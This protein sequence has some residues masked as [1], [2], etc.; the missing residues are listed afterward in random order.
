MNPTESFFTFL[1][2]ARIAPHAAGHLPV[3]LWSAD[4]ERILF[5]NAVGAAIFGSNNVPAVLQKH[6][7][8]SHPAATQIARL[9]PTLKHDAAPRLEKLRG[10]GAGFGRTLLCMCSRVSLGTQY[11]VLVVAAE[12]AGPNLAFNERIHRLIDGYEGPLAAFATDGALIH[13]T[14]QAS[15]LLASGTSLSELRN[16]GDAAIET[17]G[18]GTGA[19]V[20]ARFVGAKQTPL[21][22][23]EAVLE[24]TADLAPIAQAMSQIEARLE[25]ARA[26]AAPEAASAEPATVEPTTF[27]PATFEPAQEPS[28]APVQEEKKQEEKQEVETQEE[29]E[30]V[31]PQLQNP[32]PAAPQPIDL[33]RRHP[34]RFVWQMDTEGRFSLASGEFVDVIGPAVAAAMG[35][36]WSEIARELALDPDG[37]ILRAIATRNTWSGITVDWPVENSNER[38][39]VELSGLPIFDRDRLFRGYRGFGVCRDVARIENLMTR[40]Y[41]REPD[42][43]AVPEARPENIVPFRNGSDSENGN[44]ATLTP[45]ER[46]AFRELSSRL[47]ARLQGADALATGRAPSNDDDQVAAGIPVADLGVAA[48]AVATSKPE[49]DP[50]DPERPL[51]DRL[52]VGIL[53]YRHSHFIYANASFLNWTGH[54]TLADFSQ[55]GGLDTL[56]IET[57]A[58]GREG[59][60]GQ[61]LRIADPAGTQTPV[62]A[63]LFTI[64]YDGSTAMA[65]VLVPAADNAEMAAAIK[66]AETELTELKAILDIAAD[67]VLILDRDGTIVQ[68]NNR[69]SAI[70][71]ADAGALAGTSLFDLFAPD[72][73]RI[74]RDC[75][76]WLARPGAPKTLSEGRDVIGR[77]RAGELIS[78][79][80]TMGRI[81]EHEPKFCALVRDITAW[82]KS[83]EELLNAKRQAEKASTAKSEF[84]AKIS[85]EIRTPLNAIIGFSEVMMSE[86]FG[87]VGN[88]RY[89]DY[90]RDIHTSGEHLVSLLNDLLDLSKIEAGKLELTFTSV[91]LNEL[92][93]QTVALMQPQA[94]RERIILRQALA[95][96]LPPIHA[97]ARSVRQIAL[98]LLSNAIKFTGAGGQVIV[99]TTL[100]DR[101]DVIL[102]VKDSGAGMSDKDI[103]TA[104]EPFRQL[105]TSARYGSGGSG[106]GLPLTK[107]LTEANRATFLIRSAVNSGT[108]IEIV[109]P[110]VPG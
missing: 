40:R 95:A 45:V 68:A 36:P 76:D 42:E 9:G 18:E 38:L 107:A 22:E 12:P 70:F 20:L 65:L 46:T 110:K 57:H 26:E 83:Q 64:P 14:E 33:A 44:G 28:D 97:D 74:A 30:E 49:T 21:P 13:A 106:L 51:L 56:F 82:K 90:L 35:R 78:L 24:E 101:G 17:I 48:A 53:I 100:S 89:K 88:D 34:L 3:W 71:G 7:E 79:H 103:E 66:T 5:A 52:P 81:G 16:S 59:N 43:A 1:H 63:R 19:F 29:E 86:R 91:E 8:A 61:S 99:S 80:M 109:F 62:D 15:P 54:K 94:A 23:P 6:F 25:E 47:T 75:F 32:A 84:L 85:H 102:R 50:L 87:P 10:F 73:A 31:R 77:R 92:I 104:L 60:G 72:S 96:N 39:P 55:A 2:D 41:V 67:G 98:N 105:A 11:G 93:Q 37:E 108:L 69:V 58:D 4:G 27:E